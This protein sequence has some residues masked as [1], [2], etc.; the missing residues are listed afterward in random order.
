MIKIQ[1]QYT[2]DDFKK[3][4]DLHLRA[5]R[6]TLTGFPALLVLMAVMMFVLT[7]LSLV[8]VGS[9]DWIALLFPFLVL[10]VGGIQMLVSRPR[11]LARI[12][13]QQ[14]DLSSPFEIELSDE[15][16]TGTNLYGTY[17]IP[18]QDF[19]KWKEDRQMILLYRSDLMINF[20]PKRLLAGEDQVQYIH[21]RLAKGD[22]ADA[23]KTPKRN[24]AL[25]ILIYVLL[26]VAICAMV[27]FNL[28]QGR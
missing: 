16:Y 10:V 12:F 9:V 15:T 17:R 6:G 1:A 25:R 7:G 13:Q 14:K 2:L 18:W 23:L 21:D 8:T 4:Q 19:V 27:Y 11:Q 26:F 22:V 24:W 5:K 28:R 3:A 20:I